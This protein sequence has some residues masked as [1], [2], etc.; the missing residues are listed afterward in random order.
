MAA[1]TGAALA[2]VNALIGYR[3]VVYARGRSSE[4][5]LKVVLGGMGL[6]LLFLL[7]MMVLLITAA[8]LH[9]VALTVSVVALYAV[10]LILEILFLQG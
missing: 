10:F 9:A 2:T 1:A 3:A 5:F 7:G 6:R 4:T 8:G